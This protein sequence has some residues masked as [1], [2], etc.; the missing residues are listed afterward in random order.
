MKQ[1]VKY[2]FNKST[3]MGDK[4]L[5]KLEQGEKVTT[6][7]YIKD[8][9]KFFSITKGQ[10]AKVQLLKIDEKVKLGFA[11]KSADVV[12]AS[13]NV[14]TDKKRV[15]DVF[16]IMLDKKFTHYKKYSDDLVLLEMSIK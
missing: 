14:I 6:L 7:H 16:D 4:G 12:D 3:E 1:V 9:N 10:S 5:I 2:F 8:G 13:A 11:M 15:K